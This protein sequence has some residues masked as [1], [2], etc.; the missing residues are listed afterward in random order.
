MLDMILT[1]IIYLL[2]AIGVFFN[3]LAGIGLLRF[4]DVYT[5]LHA[6]TKCTTFGSIF[7]IGSVILIGLK[8]WYLGDVNG[9]VL[10]IHSAVAL[11]AIL[12]TNPTGA[13]AIARAAHRSGVMPENAVI[14][15][16]Q[17]KGKKQKKTEKKETED[18]T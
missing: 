16:L 18:H 17:I 6:G 7:I 8:T 5:R 9:S 11:I 2:L 4:P 14:D 13:H 12:L 3:L 1:S 15:E 10:T